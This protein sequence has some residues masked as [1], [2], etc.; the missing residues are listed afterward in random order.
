[1]GAVS[2]DGRGIRRLRS[3]PRGEEGSVPPPRPVLSI[4]VHLRVTGLQRVTHL[5]QR[6]PLS[7]VIQ[8]L[9]TPQHTWC[10]GWTVRARS[11]ALRRLSPCN[12]KSLSFA[13]VLCK[14]K[15]RGLN[16]GWWG[17]ILMYNYLKQSITCTPIRILPPQSA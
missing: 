4:P 15:I 11:S 3:G 10:S 1:M 2:A 12:M 8:P 5:F 9:P 17:E 6:V 16:L 14:V 7:P 13:L